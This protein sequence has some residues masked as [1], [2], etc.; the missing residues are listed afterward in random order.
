M[1]TI[2][3]AYKYKRIAICQCHMHLDTHIYILV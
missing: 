3:M 1:K 2:C